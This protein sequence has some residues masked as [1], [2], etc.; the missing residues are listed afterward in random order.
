PPISGVT[1]LSTLMGVSRK[2]VGRWL[3]GEMQ[4]CNDNAARLLELASEF[5]P[6]NLEKVLRADLERHRVE[7]KV[8]LRSMGVGPN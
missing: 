3:G 5:I 7:V 6:E 1:L 2:S 8:Y 4:S